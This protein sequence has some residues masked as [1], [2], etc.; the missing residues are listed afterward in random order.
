[1]FNQT[2]LP[3]LLQ[4]SLVRKSR[5]LGFMFSYSIYVSHSLIIKIMTAALTSNN[6]VKTS[7]FSAGWR[8]VRVSVMSSSFP[9][10]DCSTLTDQRLKSFVDRNQ[11]FLSVAQPCGRNT[12]H[13]LLKTLWAHVKI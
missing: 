9:A 1:L 7:Q 5:L 2:I 10:A 11:L 3:E 8:T 12:Y 13:L 4:V 6:C